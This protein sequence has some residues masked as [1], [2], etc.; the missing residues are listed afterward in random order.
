VVN[1]FGPVEQPTIAVLVYHLPSYA[2]LADGLP[3]PSTSIFARTRACSWPNFSLR[4]NR[5]IGCLYIHLLLNPYS[6]IAFRQ[7]KGSSTPQCQYLSFVLNHQTRKTLFSKTNGGKRRW[8][9]SKIELVPSRKFNARQPSDHLSDPLL[10]PIRPETFPS[11][12]LDM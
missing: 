5:L 1:H 12:L 6:S 3:M 10:I 8:S 2:S 11:S 7:P 4:R 9:V